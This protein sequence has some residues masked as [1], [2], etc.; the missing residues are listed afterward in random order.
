MTRTVRVVL[1][2]TAVLVLTAPLFVA[3]SAH[4]VPRADGATWDP[5]VQPVAKDV[6]KLRGLRFEHPV[7]VDFLT[8]AAF[9]ERIAS[10]ADDL[11]EGELADVRRSEAELRAVGLLPGDVN[12]LDA[13]NSLEQAGTLAFYD[14]G[15]K[16]ATVRGTRLGVMAKVTLA[17]ELTHALQDQHFDLIAMRRSAARRHGETALR[18][19]VEGDAVRVQNRYVASLP[20]DERREY[21]RARS[22]A[23]RRALGEARGKGVPDS[24]VVFLEA[25]Y[26]L[27][28]SMLELV[29]AANGD[30]GIDNLFRDAPADDASFVT[31]ITL[32][33]GSQ[34]RAVVP[35]GLRDGE[36]RDGPDDSFGSL[37]L[38]LMLSERADPVATL[39]VIDGWGGDAM[40]SFRRDGT[41]CLRANI[42]GRD[43]AAQ[44]AIDDALSRWVAGAP[45]G[46]AQLDHDASVATLTACDPGRGI[47]SVPDHSFEAFTVAAVRNEL[48]GDLAAGGTPPKVASCTADG[49]VADP[50]FRPLLKVATAHPDRTPGLSIIG[51]F[52]QRVLAI[53]ARCARTA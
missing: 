19:L 4:A 15:T 27:G 14:P 24:L 30:T 28:P 18:A 51:P 53:G 26:A 1:A 29:G 36:E 12:L 40:V 31:P 47:E 38:Y 25:P 34:T 8:D 39:P 7:P 11:S 35:P 33:D 41:N 3:P 52:Q 9:R 44:R 49:V 22:A 46:S 20:T 10:R 6:E 2:L 21:A 23:S 37:A 43:A 48:L 5:R 45:S 32:V 42:A 50:A 13:E 16:R 17:H